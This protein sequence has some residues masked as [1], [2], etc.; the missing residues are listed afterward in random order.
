M[1][2]CWAMSPC[3]SSASN[4]CRRREFRNT[5]ISFLRLQKT[6]ALCTSSCAITWRN[7]ARLSLGNLGTDIMVWVT[8]LAI[9]AGGATL[10]SFGLIRNASAKARISAPRVAEKSSVW[11][12]RGNISTMRVT[13][14]INPMSS[15]R[16]ASSIT[17]ILM[18]PSITLPRSAISIRRPGVAMITSGCFDKDRS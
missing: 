18:P 12:M 1:R 11:R 14:G 10:T 9:E 5:V 17:N 15:I 6:S 13:S 8:P 4:P 3:N 16:S 7:A 2:R